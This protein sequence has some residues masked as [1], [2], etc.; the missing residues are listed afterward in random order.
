MKAALR[1]VLLLVATGAGGEYLHSAKTWALGVANV[2][3]TENSSLTT[4]RPSTLWPMKPQWASHS[5]E[6]ASSISDRTLRGNYPGTKTVISR[7]P[8]HVKIWSGPKTHPT[9]K[10][11]YPRPSLMA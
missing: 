3:A 10:A 8:M 7:W 4:T 9:N 5:F 6:P 2:Y 11:H 1:L